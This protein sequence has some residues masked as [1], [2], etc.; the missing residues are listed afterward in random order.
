MAKIIQLPAHRPSK[1]GFKR[2]KKNGNENFETQ[3]DLFNASKP[4][5]QII[6]IMGMVPSFENALKLD[7]LGDSR[8]KN[9][10]LK[11]IEKGD[12]A[13]DC[14]CNLG[15]IESQ[16]GNTAK[17]ID[18]FTNA[19]KLEPRHLE[20]H[21]NLAN[22]Y[23]DESELKLARLHYEIALEIDPNFANIYFNLGLLHAINDNLPEAIKLLKHFREIAP[24]DISGNA[25]EL[26]GTLVNS[27]K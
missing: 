7:Y 13:A 20:S 3:L 24:A 27:T 19:L 15:I 23:F 12:C 14:Y 5:A 26:L 21:Y 4:D 6:P 16:M 9:A 18:C 2:A 8:A 10:Y 25:D 1:L 11:A 17:A 22:L